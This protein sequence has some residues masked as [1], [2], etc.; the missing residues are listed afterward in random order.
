MNRI[1]YFLRSTAALS[2]LSTLCA[3]LAVSCMQGTESGTETGVQG[4]EGGLSKDGSNPAAGAEVY[5]F[6]RSAAYSAVPDSVVLL[7]VL[8]NPDTLKDSAQFRYTLADGGGRYRFTGLAAGDW[9]ILGFYSDASH[10]R[11]VGFS[12]AVRVANAALTN[13]GILPLRELGGIRATVTSNGK[14]LEHAVCQ[15]PGV[16]FVAYTDENGRC[17][18][19]NLPAGEYAVSF[20]HAGYL[21]VRKGPIAVAS[22][23]ITPVADAID[24]KR[25]PAGAPPAPTG[26]KAEFDAASRIV[27]LSWD[28][29]EVPDVAGYVLYRK[30]IEAIGA[31]VETPLRERLIPGAAYR[32]TLW[33]SIPDTLDVTYIYRL[34]AMDSEGNPSTGTVLGPL[35]IVPAAVPVRLQFS[36]IRYAARENDGSMAAWVRRSGPADR[37]VTVHWQLADSS[38][39]RDSDYAATGSELSFAP[40]DTLL[41][42]Y[43]LLVNDRNVEGPETFAALLTAP[44]NG[45]VLGSPA[46]ASLAVQDDDSLSRIRCPQAAFTVS[47]KDSLSIEIRRA[48]ETGRRAVFHYQAVGAPASG[49]TAKEGEDFIAASGSLVFESGAT[50]MRIP[51]RIANDTVEEK[52]ERFLVRLSEPS[53]DV[54]LSAC[55]EITVDIAD[56]DSNYVAVPVDFTKAYT[57]HDAWAADV[58]RFPGGLYDGDTVKVGLAEHKT[59]NTALLPKPEAWYDFKD[60][61]KPE[62]PDLSGHGH[63]GRVGGSLTCKTD[64]AGTW[65]QFD[66]RDTVIIAARPELDFQEGLTV[67]A[68]VKPDSLAGRRTVVGKLYAPTSFS[69]EIVDGIYNFYVLIEDGTPQG[70]SYVLTAPATQGEW[71]RLAGTFDGKL[72]RFYVNG[73]LAAEQTVAGRLK[74]TDRP[75]TIGNWPE[76]SAYAGGMKEIKL[77]GQALNGWQIKEQMSI[78]DSPTRP[79]AVTFEFPQPIWVQGA[80]AELASALGTTGYAWKLWAADNLADL[81]AKSGS[82]SE[83]AALASAAPDAWSRTAFKPGKHKVYR[84]SVTGITGTGFVQINDV[85]LVGAER[86]KLP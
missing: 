29:A 43:A 59:S 54:D 40:G 85:N 37:P 16:S 50:S 61:G 2:A 18:L 8:Q 86:V 22:G 84:F 66:T 48:G 42:I 45:A 47:E 74:I 17:L 46:R 83:L 4:I 78:G 51:L 7:R 1:S 63:G 34:V 21:P 69:L 64:S 28:A 55:P 82:F 30:P 39:Q 23:D 5:A 3:L 15:V 38:A 36:A 13:A 35:H 14:P 71:T 65:A 33:L 57:S 77:F 31:V 19:I 26:F 10:T 49:A 53:R 68:W 72:L 32:D 80:G 52:A 12:P 41:P 24:L 25:D 67:T 79:L 73:E 56:D 81:N 62:I 11:Y 20:E 76:W 75:V 44:G 6:R 60:C 27:S 9:S 70:Y 58:S